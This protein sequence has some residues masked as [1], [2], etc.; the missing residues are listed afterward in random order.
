MVTEVQHGYCTVDDL[1]EQ[2]SESKV[3]NFSQNLM[4]RA[5]NAASRAVD[6]YTGR[7]FWQDETPQTLSFPAPL[8]GNDLWLPGKYE[9]STDTGLVVTTDDG[10]GTYPTAWTAV[11]DYTLYPYDANASGSQYRAWWVLEGTGTRPFSVR[12]VRGLYPVR[13]TAR[14][15]WSSV[16]VEVEQATLLKA[17][18]L[19]KRKDAP[20]GVAQFGDIA[21]VRITRQDID[22]IELLSEYVRD[23]A[24]VG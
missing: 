11:T 8:A 7:R 18:A 21:A 10:T 15:G 6:N 13:V 3:G 24:M 1:R 2:L 14:F 12:G 9:I 4:V 20:F 22:V 19:F 16:P 17:A 23:A 5:V